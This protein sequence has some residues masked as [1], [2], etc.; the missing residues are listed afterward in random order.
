MEVI[1]CRDG[2]R[3]PTEGRTVQEEGPGQGPVQPHQLVWQRRMQQ[4]EKGAGKKGGGQQGRS[5][6]MEANTES[7]SSRKWS[8]LSTANTR[9]S[10]R[11]LK[12]APDD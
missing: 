2:D 4:T 5:G 10:K 11:D 3:V 9:S 8:T 12:T 1:N 6:A 7:A